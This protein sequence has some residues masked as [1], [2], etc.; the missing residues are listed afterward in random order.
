MILT[1]EYSINKGLLEQKASV[2]LK[3]KDG[4]VWINYRAVWKDN[5][6]ELE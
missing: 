3:I 1:K 4:L 5:A 2:N 6:E